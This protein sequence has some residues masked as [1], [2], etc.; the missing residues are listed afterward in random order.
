MISLNELEAILYLLD[1][2]DEEVVRTAENRLFSE[3]VN[4]IPYLEAIWEN[5]TDQSARERIEIVIRS[6][7]Q[8]NLHQDFVVWKETGGQD[9]LEACL[10]VNRIQY[11]GL[12]TEIVTRFIDK[13][14]LDAW[15]AM[16]SAENPL[17]KIQILN[18]ILFERQGI[19][20]NTENYHAI[21]NSFIHR[22]VES[23]EANPITICNLYSIIAQ[24]LGM[25]VFGVNLP[26]H[27][28]L[29]WCEELNAEPTV[30]YNTIPFLDRNNYGKVLFYIN[31][32]SKG[33]VFLRK[34]ID[35]FLDAIK[36]KPRP[37]FYE[38]CSNIEILRRMLRN[39]NYSYQEVQ[40][41]QKASE[42]EAYMN[43]LGLTGEDPD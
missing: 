6:I 25:P 13:I 29:A 31:P 37:E 20:G 10:L 7:Q 1:D 26:Q 3:G 14:R 39:L 38:P 11:P 35:E 22:L 16:Y 18:H 19:S 32:F 28:V 33:Q 41:H 24:R 23:K 21:D 8:Q 5:Q 9:L 34:N 4:V 42:V 40:N 17:D 12:N 2:T 43:L 27:F 36:V 30:P 15:M